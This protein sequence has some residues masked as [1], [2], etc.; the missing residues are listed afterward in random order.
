MAECYQPKS[1]SVLP[2][3]GHHDF[4]RPRMDKTI[5]SMQWIERLSTGVIKKHPII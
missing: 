3:C 5:L 2:A 1:V 4:L